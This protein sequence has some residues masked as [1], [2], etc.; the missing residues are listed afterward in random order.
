MHYCTTVGME[1]LIQAILHLDT[2]YMPPIHMSIV[3]IVL[4][5]GVLTMAV[6][7]GD[8]WGKQVIVMATIILAV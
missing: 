1:T 5:G 3:V 8:V 6:A 2:I 4:V 7:H